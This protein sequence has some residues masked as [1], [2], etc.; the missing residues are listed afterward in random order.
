MM[1]QMIT[2]TVDRMLTPGSWWLK[3]LYYQKRVVIGVL[4]VVGSLVN[5]PIHMARMKP[6][7]IIDSLNAG[8]P[9]PLK[10]YVDASSVEQH[11]QIRLLIM[12]LYKTPPEQGRVYFVSEESEADC[13]I[14][15]ED[16]WGTT[17]TS[18]VQNLENEWNIGALPLPQVVDGQA[19][20]E[21]YG[22]DAFEFDTEPRTVV[23]GDS[24]GEGDEQ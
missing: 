20:D 23:G 7:A 19:P 6:V 21:Y 18:R 15:I 1:E 5:P 12:D 2:K 13:V 22:F 17:I 9:N 3:Y 4:G 24:R 14:R 10:V 8:T 16:N 11:K